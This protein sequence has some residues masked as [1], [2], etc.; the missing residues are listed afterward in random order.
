MKSAMIE[1]QIKAL[2][3]TILHYQRMKKWAKEQ[4]EFAGVFSDEMLIS[5]GEDWS[6]AF[7]PLCKYS[8]KRKRNLSCKGSY[9]Q[10][11]PARDYLPMDL[12]CVS[13]WRDLNGSFNWGMWVENAERLIKKAGIIKHSLELWLLKIKENPNGNT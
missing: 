10:F 7:C 13:V 11:C 2:D 12:T 8:I 9:C 4:P 5:I 1:E 6:A 3:E